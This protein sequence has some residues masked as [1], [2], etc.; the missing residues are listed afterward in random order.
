[1]DTSGGDSPTMPSI[2][3]RPGAEVPTRRSMMMFESDR[4]AIPRQLPGA[5]AWVGTQGAQA[6]QQ[7]ATATRIWPT[8]PPTRRPAEL[9]EPQVEAR[10]QMNPA[11]IDILRPPN[12]PY[13]ELASTVA[14]PTLLVV[15][16]KTIVT[17]DMAAEEQRIGG[18]RP[19]KVSSF[20][21]RANGVGTRTM[22]RSRPV[23]GLATGLALRERSTSCETPGLPASCRRS[24]CGTLRVP[25]RRRHG[26]V[27]NGW[28]RI[29]LPSGAEPQVPSCGA[30]C[31]SRGLRLAGETGA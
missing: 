30:S 12:P 13:R 21:S 31:S 10:L 11:A 9:V 16:D 20:T 27:A 25:I 15:G 19:L 17:F 4:C 6:L 3:L 26:A 18:K 29:R 5:T 28:G 8:T 22:S 24:A 23:A 14:V 2:V 7:S 1:M